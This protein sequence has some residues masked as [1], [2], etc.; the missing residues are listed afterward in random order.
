M[1]QSLRT[2]FSA[3]CMRIEVT[4]IETKHM[5]TTNRK[6]GIK[7]MNS[8]VCTLHFG[9]NFRL[10]WLA[11]RSWS[12]MPSLHGAAAA[13]KTSFACDSYDPCVP[14]PIQR[15]HEA[16]WQPEYPT[17]FLSKWQ[18]C[19]VETCRKKMEKVSPDHCFVGVTVLCAICTSNIF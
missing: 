7:T 19:Q 8:A 2:S 13:T 6:S 3:S 15:R 1:F 12:C 11:M 4:E 16:S 9:L 17:R 10:N 5:E 14:A 18:G